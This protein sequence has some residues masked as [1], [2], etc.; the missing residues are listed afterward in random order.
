MFMPF[1]ISSVSGI[2]EAQDGGIILDHQQDSPAPKH[3]RLKRALKVLLL[4]VLSVLLMFV[5]GGIVFIN[6]FAAHL[7]NHI[8]PLAQVNLEDYDLEKTSYIY[9]YNED[10]DIQVLQQLYT[11][12]DRRWAAYDEL[13]QDL[14]NAAIAIEDKRFYQHQGVDWITTAKASLNL[15]FGGDATFGGSTLTQQLIKNLYMTTDETADDITVQRKVVEI[16]RA[17]AFEKTYDKKV[18][19]EWYMNCIYFGNGCNGVKSAADYYFGKELQELT[20]AEC[21][22]LIGITN[23]PSL[24]N[25]YRT[26]LDHYRGEKLTGKERNRRRQESILKAMYDQQWLDYE[27]YQQAL[28]QEMVFKSGINRPEGDESR[29][30]YSWYVDT[31]LE[32][33]AYELARQ[34]GLTQWND[35]IRSHYIN[36]ITRAGYHIYTPYNPK[37]QLAVDKIYTDLSQIPTTKSNQ[38]LQSGIVIIDNRSGDIVAMAGGVGEKKDFD[39]YNRADVPLQIGSSIKPLTVYGPAFERGLITPATVVEDMPLEYLSDGTPFPRN[40]NRTYQYQRTIW[41]GIVSSVNAVAA[42]TLQR[43]GL[44]KSYDFATEKLGITTLTS[45]LE[46]SSGVMTDV[47]YA[48]LALGALTKG[49]TVREVANAYATFANNGVWRKGRTF[50]LVLDDAGEE[51]LKPEQESRTV[52]SRKTVNYMNYCL[53]SAVA[54]GTGTAADLAQ[55]LGMDVAGK[56]GT[57]SGNRDRYFAGFTGYYT[58]AVWCGYDSPEEIVLTGD[59]GNPAARLWKKVMLQLHRGLSTIPLYSTD[60]MELVPICLDSGKLATDSCYRDIRS[61][62]GVSRVEKVW[63]YPKDKPHSYCNQHIS[64]DYCPQGHGVAN[65][66]CKKFAQIGALKLESKAL[67]KITDGQIQKLLRAKSKGLDSDYLRNDYVYL[68]DKN[69]AAASFFGMDGKINQ[70]LNV[71]YEVCRI[72]T[73]QSWEDYQKPPATT[74]PTQPTTVPTQPLPTT[75]PTRPIPPTTQATVPSIPPTEPSTESTTAPTQPA[76]PVETTTPSRPA[77]PEQTIDTETAR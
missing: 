38:Q 72:H 19:L 69:G 71:P 16:F 46:T 6:I 5:V 39:A 25:P 53:D 13:P 58:A 74:V 7:Q 47:G 64:L 23:N 56:T 63:V 8:L 4:S 52:F 18:V 32:D 70:G 67:L 10:G 14:I 31:V 43:V 68:V 29:Q 66:Y 55:E 45:N 60:K 57:T 41:R 9:Y 22:A 27:S 77:E 2:F 48:P 34:D 33:V 54:T 37:A 44:Q 24:Y 21:A 61:K 1:L 75:E 62:D 50:F 28:S 59:K 42:H 20:T 3:P 51:V 30:V 36:L 49:I 65:E 73:K 17:I 12:T 35:T 11:T 40:D 26:S 15:L 76:Q